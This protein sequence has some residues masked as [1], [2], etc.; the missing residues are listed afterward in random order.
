MVVFV[1]ESLK[2]ALAQAETRLEEDKEAVRNQRRESKVGEGARSGD[3]AKSGEGAGEKKELGEG[4][5]KKKPGKG[6]GNLA[7]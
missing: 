1:Q 5:E 4:G 6:Y 7:K 2:V 3:G